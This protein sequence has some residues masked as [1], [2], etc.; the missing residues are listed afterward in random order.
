MKYTN[1]KTGKEYNRVGNVLNAT[2]ANDGEVMVLYERKGNF[3]V[4]E[5]D[6][7]YEKF[8]ITRGD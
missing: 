6:E 5:V 3:Y 8:E 4:R 1:K 7:F 2:N